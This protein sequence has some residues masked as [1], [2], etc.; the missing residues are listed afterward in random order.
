[1]YFNINFNTNYPINE[2]YN[3]DVSWDYSE[4]LYYTLIIYDIDAPYPEENYNSPI[5]HLLVTNIHRNDVMNGN[6]IFPF[7]LPNPPIN[8]NEHRYII[9]LY[10][11]DSLIP[12]FTPMSR[13]KFPLNEFIKQYRLHNINN[14]II[15]VNP[16]TREFILIDNTS[17]NSL[18]SKYSQHH[19]DTL[20]LP[21]NNLRE[22][23]QKYCSCIVDVATKQGE[24]CNLDKAWFQ[25]RDGHECYN[26]YAVCSKSTHGSNR[27]C[28]KNYNYDNFSDEQLRSISSLKNIQGNDRNS[29]INILKYKVRY[30]R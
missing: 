7:E 24:Q 30:E 10:I 29:L 2:L 5:I 14:N 22:E 12:P 26:P 1:M 9:G 15:L 13:I 19:H 28:Y 18:S 8:S 3:L 17:Q 20:L 23:E 6:Y 21:N 25:S 16:R 27:N 11:Q 4:S